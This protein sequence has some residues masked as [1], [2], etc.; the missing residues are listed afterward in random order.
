MSA[1]DLELEIGRV[2]EDGRSRH[3]E[4]SVPQLAAWVYD[5]HPEMMAAVR[6][7]W[8]VE[9][10]EWLMNRMRHKIERRNGLILPGF[11]QLPK[12]MTRK[13]GSYMRIDSANL[14]ELRKYRVILNRRGDSRLEQLDRLIE[15]V[16]GYARRRPGISVW[17]VMRREMT[18]FEQMVPQGA[19]Q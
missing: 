14:S 18:R 8:T 7:R 13:D 5:R 10:F 19:I 12:L 2:L 1:A 4:L 17:E 6:R 16:Q 11:E 9:R 15:L 3:P